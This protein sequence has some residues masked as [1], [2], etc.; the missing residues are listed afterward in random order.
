[1]KVFDQLLPS[2]Y[3]LTLTQ[4]SLNGSGSIPTESF[5]AQKSLG[6]HHASSGTK[7]HEPLIPKLGQGPSLKFNLKTHHK[8]AQ[9]E[10]CPEP[11]ILSCSPEAASTNT[12]CV[13]NPGGILVHTQFWDL[14][15]GQPDSWG[16]HG[17]W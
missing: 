4:L 5:T 7:G 10:T 17:L 15:V 8:H 16:I 9:R 11:P 1:M 2:L 13:V 14:N 3:G 12:C 6:T